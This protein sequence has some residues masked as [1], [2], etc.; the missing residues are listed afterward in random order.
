[1]HPRFRSREEAE[2]KIDQARI[3]EGFN[4]DIDANQ[5]NFRLQY[6]AQSMYSGQARGEHYLASL[7]DTR[8]AW[9]GDLRT[10][11]RYEPNTRELLYAEGPDGVYRFENFISSG[12]VFH[13]DLGEFG[14][15]GALDVTV[16]FNVRGR[17]ASLHVGG[18]ADLRTRDVYT[19]RLRF[20]NTSLDQGTRELGPNE[21]LSAATI[22]PDSFQIQEATFPGDNYEADQQIA[23]LIG[24]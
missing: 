13:Q 16:P 22:A 5:R 9:R 2:L 24:P 17:D 8:V 7:G 14:W 3:L 6:L 1:M 4:D 12:S 19:R 18:L 10:A 11:A 23:V 21:I 15:G 20:I